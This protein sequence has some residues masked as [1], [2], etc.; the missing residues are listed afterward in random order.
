V[1]KRWVIAAAVGLLLAL[2]TIPLIQMRTRRA[3]TGASAGAACDAQAKPANLNFV[4][5]DMNGS[6]VSLSSYKGRVILI[7]FWA[8]WCG[9]C[10]VEIPS[11]VDIYSKYKDQG[12]VV[13]GVSVDDPAEQLKPFATELKMNYPVLVG[14]DRD[15]FQSA[16][17]NIWAIP[18]SFLIDRNGNV[19]RKIM[20]FKTREQFEQEVK[21]IL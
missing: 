7:N 10:R 9:P 20:G 19:C 16:F 17:G 3:G 15:D 21:A 13:L 1:F 5:S 4:L 6:K 14:R 8:T 12:F 11:L 2:V 18:T